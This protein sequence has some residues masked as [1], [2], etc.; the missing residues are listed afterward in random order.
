MFVNLETNKGT[1]QF[2]AYNEHSGYYGHE[3]KVQC[4][5]LMHSET[6]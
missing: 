1:L 4:T 6:L 2:V 5:Q 3:A